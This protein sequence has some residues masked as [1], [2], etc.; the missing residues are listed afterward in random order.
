MKL[1]QAVS[2]L[3][4]NLQRTLY[5]R[6]EECWQGPLSE[7]ERQLVTILEIVQVE[8]QIPKSASHQRLGRKLS[9]REAIAR[10][11]V[12]KAVYGHPFTRTTIDALYSTPNLRL[13]CGFARKCDIPSES[14]FSRSF[15]E[16]AESRLGERVHDAMVE[17]CLKDRIV[18]HISRDSTAIRGHEKPVKKEKRQKTEPQRR[19]RPKKGEKREPQTRL[20]RQCGQSAKEALE[21]LPAVCNVATKRNSKGYMEY[22]TGYKLHADVNDCGLPVSIVLTAASV[23]DSQVAIPMIKMTSAKVQYLYD[24]MDPAYDARQIY[25]VSKSLGHVPIIDK[26]SRGKDVVPLAPHEAKRYNERTAVERFNS[27]IKEEFGAKNV[28]V[29]GAEKVKL[30]LMF[31]VMALFAD[32]LMK[33][34]T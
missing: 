32:Q 24:L 17:R 7:K 18:G 12:A 22:W 23:H 15:A 4:G 5:P 21:E 9:Q 16:F 26:N 27:R 31:G 30:H 13:I 25:E 8:K 20:E 2:R 14:T 19:G 28:M 29:R 34:V 6:L 3:L 1:A 33:L 10:S 11:F